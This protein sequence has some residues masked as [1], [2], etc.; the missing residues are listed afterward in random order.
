MENKKIKILLAAPRGFCAGVVRAID[1]VEKTLEKYGTPVYV[2]H[3]I[4]HNKHVVDALK[5]K[6]AIFVDELSQIKDLSRPVIFSAHGVPKN[7]PRE[8]EEKKIF[9]V[10][11]TCPLVT[12]VH[13]EAE[14]HNKNGYKIILIGHKGHPEVI[15]TMGQIPNGDIILVETISDANN[16][17]IVD[18]VAY[19]TQ[20][21]LSVDDTKDII[22]VLKKKFPNIK[23]PIKEDIC[24]ATTNRQD[25][26]KKIASECDMFFVIGSSNSSNSKRL[27]EVAKKAGCKNSQLVNFDSELPIKKIIGC[28]KI[29]LTSGA[30]APEK[31]VQEFI[32]KIKMY[33]KVTIEE[34]EIVKEN[35]T[36][37]LPSSLN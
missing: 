18:P 32:S 24:Y 23:G 2:R 34:I 37:K 20:T 21:T 16:L 28:R 8:A 26:V 10:D 31:L 36:F 12:K 6:G 13:R 1:I 29:G 19:V 30:S 17:N 4:V 5:K 7:V 15:G 25:A 3:E 9:Y 35:V 11:A 33:S 22:D 27:V 14:R